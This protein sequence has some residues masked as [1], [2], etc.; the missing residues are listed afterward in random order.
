MRCAGERFEIL[1]FMCAL[2]EE[3]DVKFEVVDF[4]LFCS[5]DNVFV[6]CIEMPESVEQFELSSFDAILLFGIELL[7]LLLE[8]SENTYV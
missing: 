4:S 8:T 5:C 2:G 7:V 1:L 6:D 3:N